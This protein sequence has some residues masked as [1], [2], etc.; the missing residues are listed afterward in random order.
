[1]G[2]I[3]DNWFGIEAPKPPKV[4]NAADTAATQ[5]QYNL[6]ALRTNIAS[7]RVDQSTPFGSLTWAPTG[8]DQFG[9]TTYGATTQFSPENQA[10]LERL[11]QNKQGT[12]GI[13]G[14]LIE[15]LID[16][17]AYGANGLPDLTSAIQPMID[18]QLEYLDPY[19]Q[20]QLQ[21]REAELRNRGLEPGNPGYDY[22]RMNLMQQQDRS[23]GDYLNKFTDTAMNLWNMPLN[24]IQSLLKVSGPV[25][26]SGSDFGFANVPGVSMA[27]TDFA[28]I[29]KSVGDL[30]NTQ[31]Q[32]ELAKYNSG[33]NALGTGI[34]TIL[35]AP[36]GTLV[37]NATGAVGG[38]LASLL[39]L[40]SNSG[41]SM[42]IL[43]A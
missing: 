34:S 3:L 21:N 12:G 6:D 42:P 25:T 39:G 36:S 9:N 14:N 37:G 1:M 26:G 35:G 4:P 13:A 32:Q 17:S 7:N 15:S 43:R 29:T 38:G 33:I 28:G 20:H 11:Q 18:R 41:G 10:L 22:E 5:A 23:V 19:F 8:V 24:A 40:N 31:Y 30:L 2:Q 16:S 27:N